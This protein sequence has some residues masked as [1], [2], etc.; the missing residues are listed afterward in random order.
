MT[1]IPFAVGAI[2]LLFG[3]RYYWFVAVGLGFL[4]GLNMG[5]APMGEISSTAVMMGLFFGLIAGVA[6]IFIANL[7]LNLAGFILGGI[8]MVGI[9]ANLE[10]QTDST[11][12]IFLLGGLL[13]LLI[14][15]FAS[16][17]A[18]ILLSSLAGAAIIVMPLTLEVGTTYLLYAALLL[19]GIV[20]QLFLRQRWS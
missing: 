16:D 15:V 7:I 18:K 14:A 10:V 2:L 9:F 13:G 12:P 11:L 20:A 3:Y 19:G 8:L 5:S 17:F 6:T 4:F 1:Y